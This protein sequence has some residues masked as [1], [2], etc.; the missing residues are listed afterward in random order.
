M[1]SIEDSRFFDVATTE[2]PLKPE[3]FQFHNAG[4]KNLMRKASRY[5]LIATSTRFAAHCLISCLHSWPF[6]IFVLPGNV[7]IACGDLLFLRPDGLF[8]LFSCGPDAVLLRQDSDKAM[9]R[10]HC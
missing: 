5:L 8:L 6:S 9:K 4:N 1:D 7:K 10:Q 3:N 2:V